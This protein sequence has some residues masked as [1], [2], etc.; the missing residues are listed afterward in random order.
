MTGSR[1]QA[2]RKPPPAVTVTTALRGLRYNSN[3]KVELVLEEDTPSCRG[4]GGEPSAWGWPGSHRRCGDRLLVLACR[5]L[6]LV[7]DVL[8]GSAASDIPAEAADPA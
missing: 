7:P 6:L 2:A 8:I 1:D 4:V 3:Y 5:L